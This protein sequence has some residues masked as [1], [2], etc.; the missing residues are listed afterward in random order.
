MPFITINNRSNFLL[1][2][3]PQYHPDS[4]NYKKFWKENKKRCIEGF[5]AQDTKHT[6]RSD[7]WRWMPSYLYFYVN[8]GTILHSPK[9]SPKTAPKKKVRPDLTDFEWEYFYNLIECKGFSGFSEDD[10][11]CCVRELRD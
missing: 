1:K 10:E 4:A 7:M 11:V 2:E 6:D 3:I 8:F 5:W 9:G